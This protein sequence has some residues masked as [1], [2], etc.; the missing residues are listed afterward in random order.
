MDIGK[1]NKIIYKSMKIE[2]KLKRNR[3]SARNGKLR[4]KIRLRK[5][6]IFKI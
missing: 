4:K 3:E 6:N 2:L 5:K 1:P